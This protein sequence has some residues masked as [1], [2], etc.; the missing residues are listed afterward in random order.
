M[1]FVEH[2]SNSMP[3][4][5]SVRLE[6]RANTGLARCFRLLSGTTKVQKAGGKPHS[7]NSYVLNTA[8]RGSSR[9]RMSNLAGML[10][11]GISFVELEEFC[12]KNARRNE[13]FFLSLADELACLLYHQSKTNHIVS[14]IYL[15][16]TLEA[17]AFSFPMIY[18]TKSKD[19]R[20]SF[21][22]IKRNF[23]KENMGELAVFKQFVNSISEGELER[24]VYS[25]DVSSLDQPRMSKLDGT[26]K[27]IFSQQMK[28]G[29]ETLMLDQQAGQIQIKF[30]G[31]PDFIVSFRNAFVHLQSGSPMNI[32]ANELYDIDDFC[33]QLVRIGLEFFGTVFLEVCEAIAD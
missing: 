8:F 30:M 20:E 23:S 24:A 26:L 14:F 29:R 25:I 16:R 10:G 9:Q 32:S 3:D 31:M 13:K 15:Y 21:D 4:G 28:E 17:V 19:F 33:K 11:E 5:L 12:K 1:Q 2:L 6:S 7:L 22:Q 27:R 18:A